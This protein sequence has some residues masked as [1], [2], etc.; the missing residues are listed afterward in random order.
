VYLLAYLTEDYKSPWTYP[1]G[2]SAQPQEVEPNLIFVISP[3]MQFFC[4]SRQSAG[5]FPNNEFD[6][7]HNG[8]DRSHLLRED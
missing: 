2:N 8:D 7:E 5:N 6:L 3:R 4:R 1:I